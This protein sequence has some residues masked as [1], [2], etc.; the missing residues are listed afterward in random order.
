MTKIEQGSDAWHQQRANRITGTRIPRA[1]GEDQWAGGDKQTQWELL[2]R[3]MYR[4]AHG[5]PQ[6]P[7]PENAM[8][9]ITHGSENEPK[10]VAELRRRGWSVMD[11]PSFVFHKEH[12][13]LGMSPDGIIVKGRKGNRSA[14]EVKCP[15]SKKVV[16]SVREEKRNYWHQMQMGMECMDID[17]MLF[18]QYFPH[19]NDGYEEWVDRDP[20]WAKNYIPKAQEYMDWYKKASKD[21]KYIS[22]WSIEKEAPGVIYKDVVDT[23]VSEELAE[24]LSEL[25]KT[26]EAAKKLEARKRDLSSMLIKQHEGAFQT[27]MIR[28]HQTQGKG[29]V[30]F[31]RLCTEEKIS[32]ETQEKYRSEGIARIYAKLIG[33]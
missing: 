7:F 33:D 22:Q 29:R 21:P 9:A 12:E 24:V 4:N 10:A 23:K 8:I 2:G 17:E 32:F 14:V 25:A 19:T 31:K 5:L 20:E 1:V 28:V 3:E 11:P 26:K 16:K 30:N 6:D 13:W 27:P 18:F 15:F